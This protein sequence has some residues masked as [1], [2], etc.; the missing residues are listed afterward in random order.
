ALTAILV[1]R[2]MAQLVPIL[3]VVVPLFAVASLLLVQ[4]P[5]FALILGRISREE[6]L[7]SRLPAYRAARMINTLPAGKVLALDFP[8]AYYLDRPWLTEGVLNDPPL[9]EWIAGARNVDEV[10][11]QL[12]DQSIRYVAVTPGYGGGTPAAL[13]P[14]ARNRHDAV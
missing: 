12:H 11:R 8:A 6:F 2:W 13:F 9:R 3:V 7:A 5:P 4:F 1:R 14:L 10:I